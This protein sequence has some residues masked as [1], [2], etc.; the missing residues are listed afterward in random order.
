MSHHE[1]LLPS[2]FDINETEPVFEEEIHGPG[3]AEAV[4]TTSASASS[5]SG[6]PS[7]TTSAKA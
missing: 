3:A 1:D 6:S 7:S 4:S 2:K 5:S